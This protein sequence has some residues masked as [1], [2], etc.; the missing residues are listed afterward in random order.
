MAVKYKWDLKTK[1][2]LTKREFKDWCSSKLTANIEKHNK[3]NCT[4]CNKNGSPHKLSSMHLLFKNEECNKEH[5]C[6]VQYKVDKCDNE[7][8]CINIKNT[9][10]V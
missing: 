6:D 2:K 3:P 10:K 8:L 9:K 7:M 4:C 5:L 1:L